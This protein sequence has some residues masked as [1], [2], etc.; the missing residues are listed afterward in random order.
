MMPP[1]ATEVA[2]RVL[3]EQGEV[4]DRRTTTADRES[5]VSQVHL[6]NQMEA[7]DGATQLA[8]FGATPGCVGAGRPEKRVTAR[9]KLPQKKW[10]GLAFPTNWERNAQ[11]TRRHFS[12]MGIVILKRDRVGNLARHGPDADI[13][14]EAAQTGEGLRMERGYRVPSRAKRSRP[15]LLVS[16]NRT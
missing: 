2:E 6:V 13:D 5:E 12:T 11:N 16:I 7:G 4:L 10:T 3:R 15:P 14:T 1:N 8:T 9:S